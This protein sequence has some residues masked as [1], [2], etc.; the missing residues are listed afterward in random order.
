MYGWN[1]NNF[2]IQQTIVRSILAYMVY[3]RLL[4]GCGSMTG[5]LGRLNK[6]FYGLCKAARRSY[7]VLMSRLEAFHFKEFLSGPRVLRLRVGVNVAAAVVIHVNDI[8]RGG[9]ESDVREIV[10]AGLTH[11][12][13]TK[14]LGTVKW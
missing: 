10:A 13:P 4:S 12:L 2:D 14:H 1:L 11:T 8:V 3:V 5:K 9:G 6:S 7:K